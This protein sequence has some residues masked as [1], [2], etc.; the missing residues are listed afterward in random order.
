VI[1]PGEVRAAV[2]DLGWTLDRLYVEYFAL[3][4]N[5]LQVTLARFLTSGEGLTRLEFNK[6]ASAINDTYVER[7]GDHPV[8]YVEPNRPEPSRRPPSD[9]P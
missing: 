8:G 1:H 3:G 9:A 6:L 4:G 7:G 5:E 2:A